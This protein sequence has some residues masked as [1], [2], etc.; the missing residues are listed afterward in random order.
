MSKMDIK[1]VLNNHYVRVLDAS[2]RNF[3]RL[4]STTNRTRLTRAGS[5][6]TIDSCRNVRCNLLY[7]SITLRSQSIKFTNQYLNIFIKPKT[8]GTY[9]LAKETRKHFIYVSILLELQSDGT[10]QLCSTL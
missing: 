8:L 2:S 1:I 10:L 7:A 3:T 6:D 5:F 9:L 4:L